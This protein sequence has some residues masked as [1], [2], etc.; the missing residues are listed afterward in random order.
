MAKRIAY[1]RFE[2]PDLQ[3]E[4]SYVLLSGLKLGE[5]R[6][7]IKASKVKD[8]DMIEAG[9]ALFVKHIVGWNWVDDDNNP[10]PLPSDDPEVINDLT[11]LETEGIANLLMNPDTKN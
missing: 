1:R 4:D 11:D 2:T 9:S 6:E 10:L 8:F 3:G 5:R 7:Y